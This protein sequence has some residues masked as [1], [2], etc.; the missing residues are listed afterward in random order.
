MTYFSSRAGR[1]HIG[2][3][4]VTTGAYDPGNLPGDPGPAYGLTV[5]A[6]NFEGSAGSQIIGP[7]TQDYRV[8]SEAGAPGG[9]M[10]YSMNIRGVQRGTGTVTTGVST[11]L[12]K[13]ITIEVDKIIVN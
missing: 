5:G 1:R 7:P 6:E 3:E 13:G 11:P 10:T 4:E 9:S 2:L 12:I 8:I